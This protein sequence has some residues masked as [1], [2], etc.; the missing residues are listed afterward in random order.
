MPL[1]TAFL[2]ASI[3]IIDIERRTDLL[4]L[5]ILDVFFLFGLETGSNDGS[6][7]QASASKSQSTETMEGSRNEGRF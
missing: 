6:P 3:E 2:D 4:L 7:T 5:L 1:S